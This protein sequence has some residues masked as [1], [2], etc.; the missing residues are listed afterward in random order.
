MQ[1]LVSPTKP[2]DSQPIVPQP[3]IFDTDYEP[4]IDETFALGLL[5]NSGDLL[6]LKYVVATSELPDLSA[7]CI[8]QHLD[9]AGRSDIPVGSSNVF[10]DCSLRGGMCAIPGLMGL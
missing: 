10:T 3:V 1:G 4:F 5:L 8:T 9:L 2:P 6:D 7:K